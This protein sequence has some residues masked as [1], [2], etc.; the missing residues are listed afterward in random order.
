MDR[1]SSKAVAD[2]SR[3]VG[4]NAD[5][6][7]PRSSP[8]QQ[9]GHE[10]E[11]THPLKPLSLTEPAN[12]IPAPP[13]APESEPADDPNAE[14]A[15]SANQSPT[16]QNSAKKTSAE[17]QDVEQNA[18]STH[19]PEDNYPIDLPTVLR[20]A[21][22][23]NWNVHL[24]AERVAEARAQLDAAKALWLPSLN[25][26]VG[27]TKH[28]GQIQATEGPVIDISRNSLFVGGGLGTGRSP[29]TGG[30]GGPARLFVD[31][32]L[33]DAIFKP[34]VARQLVSA[35]RARE[36]ATF[37][38]TLLEASLAYFDLIKAQGQL[39]NAR[40]KD[41]KNATA[42]LKQTE[43]FVEAGKGSNADIA[44][45]RT[46][47]TVRRQQVVA[48]E[49]AV[50]VASAGLA[51]ILQLDP[52]TALFALEQ[53][54][55]AVELISEAHS[56]P[57]LISHAQGNRPE[58]VQKYAL[59]EAKRHQEQSERFR[60]F[61]PNI[62]VGAS[63]GAMGGGTSDSLNQLDGRSDVDILAVWQVKNL[64]Y[65]NLA[66]QATR[67]SQ[68]RQSLMAVH[69]LNDQIATE[70]TQAYHQVQ[71]NRKQIA[72]AESN[73][74]DALKSLDL[75]QQRIRALEGLPLEALQAVQAVA[76]ANDAYLTAI[77]NYNQAQ[78]RLL[79]A[80]GDPI[81]E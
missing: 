28:D 22:A 16:K 42:L 32:S 66:A 10:G 1:D 35:E 71:A 59:M 57:D 68:Y 51:R 2:E 69:Q 33:A 41:L 58:A 81:D 34:L 78:L 4:R 8:I 27:Y 21:G 48:A 15:A 29:L 26:G 20:L 60:P 38:D 70:V 55:V 23:D 45:V 46:D 43:T 39:A 73:V 6:W 12:L 37:N 25:V 64:G 5:R 17:F 65:G 75:N 30:G 7:Q 44:R 40:E 67:G 36:S 31:L 3:P 80:I 61:I 13:P 77:V 50:K 14:S 52:S 62:Y 24:A 76:Q 18:A 47:L 63:A 19:S 49:V 54:P 72:L 56:L 79:R 9:T 74:Q 53:T 11:L